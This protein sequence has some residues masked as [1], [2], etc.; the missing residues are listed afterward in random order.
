[1]VIRSKITSKGYL[2]Y[3]FFKRVSK[4]GYV[5]TNFDYPFTE[6]ASTDAKSSGKL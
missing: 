5:E 6:G 3:S 1:M 4:K 2:V